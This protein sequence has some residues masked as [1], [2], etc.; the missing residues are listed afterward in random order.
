MAVILVVD[1]ESSLL[2]LTRL[3]LEGAGHTALTT[4]NP[5]EGIEIAKSQLP[6]V[7]IVDDHMAEMDGPDVC[8]ILRLDARTAGIPIGM[9]GANYEVSKRAM[10]AGADASLGKPFYPAE[11][12]SMVDSLL[13]KSQAGTEEDQADGSDSADPP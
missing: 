13:A 11:F 10:E 12:L 2:A 7:I 6:A 8:R 1:D 4:A 3:L 9:I 5:V